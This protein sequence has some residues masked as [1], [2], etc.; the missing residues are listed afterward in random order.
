MFALDR[1]AS[2][3][4]HSLRLLPYHY[5]QTDTTRLALIFFCVSALDLLG[6]LPVAN[7]ECSP[8]SKVTKNEVE[9]WKEWVYSTCLLPTCDA[10]R[11]SP[12]TAV[13]HDASTSSAVDND[14]VGYDVGHTAGTYF[15]LGILIILRDDFSRLDRVRMMSWL[16]KCQ[17]PD[18]SF[19][20]GVIQ[21]IGNESS[22]NLE[23]YFGERDLRFGYCAAATRWFIG[24][25]ILVR[26]NVVQ[27]IDIDSV[28]AYISSCVSYDGGM[29]MG[30]YAEGHAGLTY[31]GVGTLRL[32]G[33]DNTKVLSDEVVDGL[34]RWSLMH[35]VYA[36]L[37]AESSSESASDSE[38]TSA[39]SSDACAQVRTADIPAGFNGRINKPP[40]TCY[41]FWSGATLEMLPLSSSNTTGSLGLS[42]IRSNIIFL[43][44]QTQNPMI[45]GFSKVADTP[46]DLMH[47]YLGIAALALCADVVREHRGPEKFVKS[48]LE[49]E[50]IASIL[51]L[52]SIDG[53]LC[54]STSAKQYAEELRAKWENE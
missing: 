7:Q 51:P 46:P 4:Q 49:R 53:A 15:A 44:T 17:R 34:V 24:G 22:D 43:L 6:Y 19:A 10:F 12:A 47:A 42:D 16:R 36:E 23:V 21:S 14:K 13:P 5:T 2:F 20:A 3:F 30:P 33:P 18:G 32:L 52:K 31:C 35:Q 41:S 37:D 27:D 1:H 26:K 54:L 9:H 11:C 45:G 39:S 29:A 28:A 50:I 40:D 48:P 38:V 25:D 8:K